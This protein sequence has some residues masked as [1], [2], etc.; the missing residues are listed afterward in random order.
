MNIVGAIIFWVAGFISIMLT[1]VLKEENKDYSSYPVAVGTVLGTENFCGQRWVVRFTDLSG[2]EVLGMD[3]VIGYSTFHPENYHLPK[4]KLQE[5]V[6]YY[7]RDDKSIYTINDKSVDYYIHFCD[8]TLYELTK[9]KRKK[10]RISC[11]T[12][13]IVFVILGIV[14]LLQ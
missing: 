11:I 5:K 10:S 3:D 8:E 6:Y 2:E 13:G 7:V 9:V 4:R 14:V 1:R 12:L